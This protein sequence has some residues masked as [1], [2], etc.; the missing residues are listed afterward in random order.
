M[1][2]LYQETFGAGPPLVMVP[3]W[4]MHRRVWGS[5]AATLAPDYRVTC[6]DLPGQ[7]S[8][9]AWTGWT[10]ADV[11]TALAKVR[12]G[13]AVWLGWSLGGQ[14]VLELACRYPDKVSGLVLMGTNPR[15]V[16]TKDW[17]G[18]EPVRFEAFVEAVNTDP[19]LALNRFLG[20]VCQ[21]GARRLF[22]QLRQVWHALP[23]PGKADLLRGLEILQGTDLRPQ[24][25]GIEVPVTVV[26]GG[27]D[28]LVPLEASQRLCALLPH[29]CLTLVETGGHVPF[30]VNPE[31]VIATVRGLAS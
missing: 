10:L 12:R 4:A 8:T 28:T 20:L 19:D 2:T 9:P 26:A 6:V 16:A 23:P 30:L 21:G 25:S 22:K 13:P 27:G 1:T 31:A 5:L 18:M 14:L 11:S 24:L 17:P 15:F 29:G 3:G 7:G